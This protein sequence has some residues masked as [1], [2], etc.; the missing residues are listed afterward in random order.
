MA[1]LYVY[2][3]NTLMAVRI[4]GAGLRAYLEKSAEYYNPCPDGACERV[5][6]PAVPGY[7]FDIVHGVDYTLDLARPVGSR[8]VRLERAGRSVQDDDSF[9]M[10][11]NSYR[12]GGGGGYPG[13]ANAEVVYDRGESIRD[14]LVAEVER[15][16][17]ISPADY[18]EPSWRI[19]PAELAARAAREQVGTR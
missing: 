7:N 18:F 14:L 19:V 15:R 2:D 9:T 1:R 12:A 10:A 8:V 6:N 5:T 13:L 11:L 16:G 4:S 17:V 3:N